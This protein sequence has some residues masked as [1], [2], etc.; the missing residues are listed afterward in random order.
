ME[1]SYLERIMDVVKQLDAEKQKRVLEF[2]TEIERSKGEPGWLF[3]ERTAHVHIDPE[4]LR[5][6]QQAIEEDC[7]QIDDDPGIEFPE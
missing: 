2:V 5:L 1:T 3:L 7:E 4:D 6:M